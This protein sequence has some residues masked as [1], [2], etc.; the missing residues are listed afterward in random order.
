MQIYGNQNKYIHFYVNLAF[1][2]ILYAKNKLLLQYY[3]IINK[4]YKEKNYV[5]EKNYICTNVL[6][7]II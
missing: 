1:A 3:E 2:T 4:N 6:L 7:Y 5:A